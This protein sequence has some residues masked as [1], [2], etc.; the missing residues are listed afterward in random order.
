MSEDTFLEHHKKGHD[1]YH[2]P[3]TPGQHRCLR[4]GNTKDLELFFRVVEGY[5]ARSDVWRTCNE[6]WNTALKKANK[7]AAVAAAVEA[8]K[9]KPRGGD[10]DEKVSL[11]R[12]LF[13][14]L[15]YGLSWDV[16]GKLMTSSWR[17]RESSIL[18]RA[19]RVCIELAVL[20]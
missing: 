17:D 2:L 3:N 14:F 20:V 19:G 5:S 9:R 10:K 13:F 7:A 12:L 6:C 8:G 18:W 11:G 16:I 4:C 15:F 1:E